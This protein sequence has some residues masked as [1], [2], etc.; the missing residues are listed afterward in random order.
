MEHLVFP[1]MPRSN[2][3]G[4]KDPKSKIW[5]HSD[6]KWPSYSCLKKVKS[7]IINGSPCTSENAKI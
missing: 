5:V 2:I 4:G 7:T 3:N 6:E 1:R